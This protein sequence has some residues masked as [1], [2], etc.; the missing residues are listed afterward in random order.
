M[1]RIDVENII[2]K[3]TPDVLPLFADKFERW[4]ILPYAE[5]ISD[6]LYARELF[7]RKLG[8]NKEA[9]ECFHAAV[10]VQLRKNG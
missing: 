1:N 6:A 3:Y 9:E 5:K 10:E 2:A 8:C 4:P 7:Y